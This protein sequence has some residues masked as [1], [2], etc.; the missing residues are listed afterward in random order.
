[1]TSPVQ[2]S[3]EVTHDV[4]TSAM[5]RH[6]RLLATV[7]LLALAALCFWVVVALVRA[8]AQPTLGAQMSRERPTMLGLP[9]EGAPVVVR[10]VRRHSPAADAD[11]RAGD[12]VTTIDG[13]AVA[14]TRALADRHDRLRPGDVVTFE[15]E[16]AGARL[17]R[18]LTA[19]P[20]LAG[21]WQWTGVAVRVLLVFALFLGIP[22]VVFKWRSHDPRA[23]LFMLFGTTFGLSM[24][25]FSVPGLSQPPEGVLPLPEA[26]TRFNLTSLAI[27]YGCALVINPTLLH[28]LALFPTPR[29]APVTLGRVLRWTYLVPSLVGWLAAP[30]IVVLL[31]RWFPA[32][33]RPIVGLTLAVV[34]A[35]GALRVWWTRLRRRTW[36]S[37]VLD[38][39]HWLGV[40]VALA[41][42]AAALAVIV[43]VGL[44]SRETAGLIGG[45]LIACA[46]ALF[47]FGVGIAYPI[48]CGIAMWRS[49]RLSADDVRRQIR[50]PLLSIALALGIAVLLSLL[51][52]GLSFSTGNAPP[53]W[54]FSV[55]EISTWAAYSV[56]PLAFAAAVLRYGL[57]DIRFIIRLT[58]FYLLTT[59]SVYIGTFATVLLLATAVGEATH[60]N[61]V[62]T[63]LITLLATSL[64]EPLRRRVQRRVDKHFYQRTPD[65]VGVLARHGQQLR[66]VEGRDDLERRLVLALQEAIPH[67]PT[68]LFRRREDQSEFIAAHSPDPLARQAFAALPF[69]SRRAPDLLGPTVLAEVTMEIE[70][71]RT[72]E[73]LAIEALLPVRQGDDMPVVLGL[74]RKR[75]DD[76]W[77]E[78]DMEILS[79]LAAQTSMALADI[80]AR[81]H[82]A[83]LKEAFDNQRALLPQQ[84]PQPEAYS[85]A[86]AWHPALTVGGDYYDA[87]WLSTDAVA[88]CVADVAGK[89]LA[90][91]LV[92]A[93]LQ[94]T[95]KA[96]AG[97]DVS[98]ADLC[99][100]VNETLASNLRKGRF[101]TFFYGVLRLSTGDLRY[102]NAGHNPPVL[103]SGASI[104]EL[105]LGDPGLGLLRTHAY[106][107]AQVHLGPDARLLLF[108]DGVTE[109]RS[110]DGEDFGMARLLDLVDR[111][112][113]SAGD[114]R[115]DVLSAIAAW[116]Q[117]E[118]DDDV[119]LLA[120]V[121]RQ[122]THTLF[123]SQKIRLPASGA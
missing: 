81:Q 110:P 111:P 71:A 80:E 25:N 14:D 60:S 109:G 59:A 105:A 54:L 113:T 4:V 67:A 78:R 83:S 104:H 92:M 42:M 56:I 45:L 117:G 84:L 72:W 39:A 50:W 86:G 75:S 63:I 6:R 49:W 44:R 107:D 61:R 79:S 103:A 70:E 35:G 2:V 95:V 19:A 121:R 76:S 77:Q 89:G 43:L 57:M 97:P 48:A 9:A 65:P 91:S 27:T 87:W 12:R 62:V 32:A 7:V 122:G 38:D 55:F 58:F 114:L 53:P 23:L 82:D 5:L 64:L 29:L 96:L 100:R 41:Y 93:N 99:T 24:L 16:R 98:P 74:G 85:I 112:H 34:A 15:I 36:R 66:T 119:T 20:V 108:T 1:M 17:T 8:R 11:L 101:V 102:A 28:F 69:L 31:M 88:I 33:A 40:A 90:A 13:I 51:S 106:R 10:A 47:A 73:H 118:F 68:Y 18:R 22:S 123:Q 30:V 116:T 52:I 37:R 46:V 94:A 26:F 21:A 120:V 115:D 3:T